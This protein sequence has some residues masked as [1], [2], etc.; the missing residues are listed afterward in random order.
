MYLILS[1]VLW[2]SF[3]ALRSG[4]DRHLNEVEA[5][6]QKNIDFWITAI[7]QGSSVLVITTPV[8]RELIL[9]IGLLLQLARWWVLLSEPQTHARK[10]ARN[11]V[12]RQKLIARPPDELYPELVAWN[13]GD[14]LAD[15]IKN[16]HMMIK[17]TRDHHLVARRTDLRE[18]QIDRT[19]VPGSEME[20]IKR[21]LESLDDYQSNSDPIRYPL[22][23][24]VGTWRNTSLLRREPG[25]DTDSMYWEELRLKQEAYRQVRKDSGEA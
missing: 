19:L 7:C 24:V 12:S 10:E 16:R 20:S 21:T 1:V 4:Y 23:Q 8:L 3:L 17:I 18:S 22:E 15:T 13:V 25:R 5:F 14:I 11:L 6:T 9:A 2:A